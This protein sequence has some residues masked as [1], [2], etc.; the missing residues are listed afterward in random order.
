MCLHFC[1]GDTCLWN[2]CQNNEAKKMLEECCCRFSLEERLG[3]YIDGKRKVFPSYWLDGEIGSIIFSLYSM[4]QGSV[5]ALIRFLKILMV[6]LIPQIEIIAGR[7]GRMGVSGRKVPLRLWYSSTRRSASTFS[8]A[9]VLSLWY[10]LS[11]SWWPRTQ[12]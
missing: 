6:T 9:N 10:S 8:L 11:R 4:N 3:D 5:Y 7:L 1:T 12:L 2:S